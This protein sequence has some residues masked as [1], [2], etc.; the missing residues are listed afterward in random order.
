M[1]RPKTI[2]VDPLALLRAIGRATRADLER[3]ESEIADLD[4][5][6]NAGELG[7]GAW[8]EDR[9]IAIFDKE[10]IERDGVKYDLPRFAGRELSG[11]ERIR[12]Q[13]AIRQLEA[14]GLVAIHGAKA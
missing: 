1:G 9:H 5:R 11:S 3:L 7:W 2:H 14:E 8:Q 6:K 10:A 12:H 4:R 13:Q